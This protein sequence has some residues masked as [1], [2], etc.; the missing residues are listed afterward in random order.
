MSLSS[1]KLTVALANTDWIGPNGSSDQFIP[2]GVS[3]DDYAR[4]CTRRDLLAPHVSQVFAEDCAGSEFLDERSTQDKLAY[5]L[6]ILGLLGAT[7]EQVHEFDFVFCDVVECDGVVTLEDEC[8]SDVTAL[9]L[10]D[11]AK[12]FQC[13]HSHMCIV[14]VEKK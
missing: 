4:W 7:E 9:A 8:G 6:I 13:S 10:A 2:W 5:T 11:G 14:T 3:D 12:F 1:L